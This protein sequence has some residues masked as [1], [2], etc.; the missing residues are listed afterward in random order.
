[1][2][3]GAVNSSTWVSVPEPYA[4]VVRGH[5]NEFD[6]VALFTETLELVDT[7]EPAADDECVE[8]CCIYS[9]GVFACD[10][11]RLKMVCF[12][13]ETWLAVGSEG[14]AYAKSYSELTMLLGYL[15]FKY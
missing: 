15:C 7:A 11:T 9:H 12:E 3:Y 10:K 5:V 2:R 8:N 6:I 13:I 14:S 1:M 4:R